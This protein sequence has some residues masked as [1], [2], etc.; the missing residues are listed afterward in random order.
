MSVPPVSAGFRL[1]KFVIIESLE[2]HEVKT[3]K[4]LA[5]LLKTLVCEHAPELKIEYRTCDNVS[6]FRQLLLELT[7]E[8]T[9][10]GHAP[11][12][13]IE[14]HG[15][16]SDG[17]EF[18]NGSILSWPDLAAGLTELNV[19]SQF[20]LLAVLSACFGGYLLGE[21]TALAPAACWCV[22]APTLTIDPAESMRGFRIFYTTL[23]SVG[24]AGKA[25]AELQKTA[26]SEGD[27]FAQLAQLWFERL[28]LSYVESHCTTEAIRFRAK[29]MYRRA[30]AEGIAGSVGGFARRLKKQHQQVLTGKYFEVFFCTDR[31]PTSTTRFAHVRE[32]MTKK[33]AALRATGLYEI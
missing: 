31:V 8:A 26:L 27:W 30:R 4:I 13:H 14:C 10:Q 33:L 5:E 23:L 2:A 21:I 25:A 6:E 20:N 28:L 17:L 19:A 24:D 16:K 15:S 18:A 11:V 3:G 9:Q 29:R 32:R 22:V 1:T 7:S 12:L